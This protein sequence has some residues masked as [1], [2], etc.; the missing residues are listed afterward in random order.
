MQ[1][2]TCQ[3]GSHGKSYGTDKLRL[4]ISDCLEKGQDNL[5][6][7]QVNID[8]LHLDTITDISSL[9]AN[10]DLA[11]TDR[12]I[13]ASVKA[14]GFAEEDCSRCL[15]KI[16]AKIQLKFHEEYLL[17]VDFNSNLPISAPINAENFLIGSDFILDLN[18]ALRQHRI[19]TKNPKPLCQSNCNGIC[20]SCGNNLNRKTCQCPEL[21]DHR[22]Q[23]LSEFTEKT[24]R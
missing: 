2:L 17:T 6:T 20:P 19:M 7:L 5:K 4:D 11:K 16:Q 18:E 21:L 24:D 23:K 1:S 13:L 12:G 8:I 9:Q 3:E 10:I 22:W 15:E 14:I